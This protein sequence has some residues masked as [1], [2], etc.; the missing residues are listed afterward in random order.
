MGCES[1]SLGKQDAILKTGSTKTAGGFP[2]NNVK[3]CKPTY[4]HGGLSS[5]HM[6]EG[7]C[8][9]LKR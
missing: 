4:E 1:G 8:A 5:A 7:Q 3:G 2:I 9:A 6:D